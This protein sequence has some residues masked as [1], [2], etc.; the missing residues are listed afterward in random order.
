[1]T[2]KTFLSLAVVTLLAVLGAVAAVL[3]QPV[4]TTVRVNS[5]LAFKA[6]N[7]HPEAAARMSI[8]GRELTVNLVRLADG[9]WGAAD[10]ANYPAK[11]DEIKEV[12]SKMADMHLIE[13]KTNRKERLS[14]LVL[15]EPTADK[16]K[17]SLVKVFDDKGQVLAEAII[18]R[19]RGR[20]TGVERAGTYIRRPNEQQAWL[21]SGAVRIL[22]RMADWLNVTVLHVEAKNVRLVEITPTKGSAIVA[23]KNVPDEAIKVTTALPEKKK[24]RDGSTSR[25]AAGLTNV[26][27]DDVKRVADVKF[28]EERFAVKYLTFDGMEVNATLAKID[29]K[30]W[31]TFSA[32]F[33]GKEGQSVAEAKAAR[34][35]V[36]TINKTATG[37]AYQLQP[38][39]Y[40]R[41]T[42]KL[43]DML[44]D[45][46]EVA[47][48]QQFQGLPGGPGGIPG[49]PQ[50]ANPFGGGAAAGGMAPG[51]IPLPR[52]GEPLPP[53]FPP[54][55]PE[56]L[57]QLQDA[58]A[59]AER[60][61]APAGATPPPA[62]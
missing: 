1:M 34:D 58:A 16:S 22:P 48:L 50:G 2:P 7:A 51:G 62:R 55:P 14:R 18:G 60:G 20:A 37:W 30:G 26:D 46:D 5:E 15:E 57:K 38:H 56:V 40:E 47:P 41:L 25:F 3:S 27:L 52:A 59:A 9:V 53:G 19:T 23:E 10:R 31:A 42:V 12:L 43:E 17:S 44:A 6:L 21:A 8:E 35:A 24:I 4:I 54:M 29:D 61:D 36:D 28:P 45:P 13:A 32:K 11:S 33:I 49:M 39:V